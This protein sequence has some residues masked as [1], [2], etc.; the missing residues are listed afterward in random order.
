MI[1]LSLRMMLLFWLAFGCVAEAS[2]AVRSRRAGPVVRPAPRPE[3]ESPGAVVCPADLDSAG[4]LAA[5]EIRRYVYLRTGVLLRV[6]PILPERGTAVRLVT[7]PEL[8]PQ[9]YTLKTTDRAGERVLTIAGGSGTAVLYGAY[10]FIEKLGVRFHVHGDVIPDGKTALCI[11]ELNETN[12]PL[13]ALRGLQPF[14]DFPEGPDWW[15]LDDWKHVVSQV[16]KMRMNFIGLHTY[17]FQNKDLGPEPTVWIGLPEDVNTDGTVKCSDAT[18]WYNTQ[19][20]QPYGCYRPEKTSAFS[21]GGAQLFPSDNYGPE[22]NGPDDFPFP[23]TPGASVAL[24]NRTGRMLRE[25]FVE[26]HR[27][28]VKTCVGTESPLD[29]PDVV[30]VRLQEAGMSPEA[31]E[32]LQRLYEGMFL[33]IQRAYPIDY[34]WIWGHEGEI[35]QARFITNLHCAGAARRASQAPFGLGICGWGWI[36]QNFPALDAVLPKDVFFSA[37]SM[38]VGNDPVSPNFGRLEGRQ[39]WAIPWFE[40]DPALSSPQLWVGRMRKDAADARKYGCTGL[41]GLHWRTRVLSPNIAALAQAGWHQGEWSRPAPRSDSLPDVAALGGNVATFNQTPMT[42]S[43][44]V[45]F[46]ATADFYEDWARAQFGTEAATAVARIFTQLD[47]KFPRASTWNQGPGVVVVNPQPWEQVAREY[48]FV[49]ELAAL[50]P[51]I[52]GAGNRER[53]DWWL[54][55]FRYARSMAQV[56]CARGALDQV[57]ARI[58]QE[59]DPTVQRRLA[60]EQALPQREELV[61]LLAEMY[62]HLLATVHNSSELGAVVNIEQQSLLRTQLLVAHDERLEQLLGEPLPASTRLWKDYRGPARLVVLTARGSALR[63]EQLVLPI[64]ALDPQ[65]VRSLVVK[66]R[67]LGRGK[68]RTVEARHVGRAVY[69]AHLPPAQE[70]FEYVVEMQT[71]RSQVVRWPATAPELNQSVVVVQ[72]D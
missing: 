19:K 7:N 33:R 57:M 37:I 24:M 71:A 36:T 16:A 20:Y 56:G 51:G 25:V 12:Q 31:P 29:I 64:I 47:G 17:P 6:A 66:T 28:G 13:F 67:P 49:E 69:R 54:N 62:G 5:R 9:D 65:P 10:A 42:G 38:S 55:T 52:R 34:Y 53:F 45:R 58:A 35:D 15:T 43:E 18:T 2:E 1:A 59:S 30:K 14:H 60:R 46:R 22:V 8:G 32:T 39:K 23:K 68:W 3:R 70:D 50:S 11:P 48:R 27:L 41:M 72:S 61:R 26:A 40:D 21:F 44:D 63:G 4:R